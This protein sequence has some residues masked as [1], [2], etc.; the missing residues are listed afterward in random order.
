MTMTLPS[1]KPGATET[2][3]STS[4]PPNELP[5]SD[6]DERCLLI[7]TS[8]TTAD[9]KGVQHTTNTLIAEIRTTAEAV[10]ERGGVNLA[11]FPAGHIAG[12]T[13]VPSSQTLP[14]QTLPVPLTLKAVTGP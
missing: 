13:F 11:A 12:A 2:V 7:Y 14:D 1:M 9:P 3:F 5:A 4:S 8:G 6:P 10:G